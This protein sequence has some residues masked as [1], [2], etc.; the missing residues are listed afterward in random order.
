MGSQALAVHLLQGVTLMICMGKTILFQC[1]TVLLVCMIG[2][3]AGAQDGVTDSVGT[4]YRFLEGG[5]FIQGTTGGER[6]LARAFPLST[7]GQ[8]FGNAEEPAH[9]TWVTTPFL[10]AQTEVTVFQFR[11]FVEATGY[12]TSAEKDDTQMVGW[13]PTPEEK[14]LYQSYDFLRDAKF[15]WRSPGFPQQENHPVVGVSFADAKAYCD[16]LS[17]RDGV[18]YRLPTEAEWEFACRAGTSTWFSFGDVARGVAHQYGNLGNVE[19]E[20]H[21][22]HAAERQWLMDWDNVP[23]DGFVF[24]APVGHYQP[25]AFELHDMHG[26]VWEWCEDLWLDTI[27]KDYERPRYNEPCGVAVNPVNTDRPQTSTNDFHVIR[28]GSWYNGDLICRSANRAYWDGDDAACYVGFRLVREVEPSVSSVARDL[29]EA[30]QA[31]T[32]KITAAGGHLYSSGGIDIEV[33]FDGDAFDVGAL[34]ALTQVSDL[35]GLQVRWR[36]REQPLTQPMFDAISRLSSLQSLEISS[37]FDADAIDLSALSRLPNL[38]TLKFPRNA[39]LA[40]RHLHMLAGLTT[41][42]EF[43]CFGVNGGLTDDGLSALSANRQ[44]E[45]LHAEENLATGSFLRHFAGCPLRSLR[46]T[47]PYNAAGNCRDEYVA[48]LRQFPSLQSLAISR[49][50]QL[51]NESLS[52]LG[53]LSDLREL[54][55][56]DCSR[57]SDSGYTALA[58]LQKLQRLDVIDSGAGD[59]MATS[60]GAIPR[61][62]VVRIATESLGDQ[63]VA[64]L[65]QAFSIEELQLRCDRVSDRGVSFLGRINRLR[66]LQI[67]SSQVTGRGLGPVC[68]LPALR[69]LTLMTP[70]LTDVAF[71]YLSDA[72]SILKL[73]LA[74]RGYRPPAA[75]TDEG[76]MQMNKAVWLKEFWLPRNDTG[77]SEKQIEALKDLLPDTNVIPYTVEWSES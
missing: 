42:R 1:S 46:M 47:A 27:Y 40:D 29:Y 21:R 31:A 69:D 18:R 37:T 2:L 26:N 70:A 9:V 76:L 75:L 17:Q 12:Q 30:E 10:I 33:R 64:Q 5:R 74:V 34:E 59:Q 16:W 24:T 77:I 32:A 44:L 56:E 51:T 65:A 4:K 28:G 23:S 73:S 54:T 22:K 20:K 38:M 13:D 60:I 49:Q 43:Q 11:Q 50:P 45:V 15:S 25:N 8:F 67:A 63:G 61:I 7:A 66:K 36:N 14:P 62:R 72:H 58:S 6:A 57:L 68:S 35:R 39:P 48:L 71:S 41:L 3:H 53:Q 52:V 19:L 55:I